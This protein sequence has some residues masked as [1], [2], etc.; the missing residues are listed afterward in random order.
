MGSIS[1]PPWPGLGRP[2]TKGGSDGWCH[3]GAGPGECGWWA[4]MALSPAG[5]RAIHYG[6]E[7][8]MCADDGQLPE[9]ARVRLPRGLWARLDV[10]TSVGCKEST[11]K[12]PI[13]R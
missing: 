12:W 11:D 4:G 5:S 13:S 6:K 8:L 9:G 10:K 1:S 2:A 7:E 3:H